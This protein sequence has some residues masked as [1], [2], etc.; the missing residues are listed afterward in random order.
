[1]L[2]NAELIQDDWGFTYTIFPFE[3]LDDFRGLQ[4]NAKAGNHDLREACYVDTSSDIVQTAG[5][6]S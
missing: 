3:K 5:P 6:K 1:M 4:N 2:V